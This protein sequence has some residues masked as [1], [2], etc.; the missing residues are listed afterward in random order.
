M[1]ALCVDE[2]KAISRDVDL[3]MVITAQIIRLLHDARVY[4]DV[5]LSALEAAISHVRCLD[6]STYI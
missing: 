5:A 1:D 2:Q 6:R 4:K 3:S